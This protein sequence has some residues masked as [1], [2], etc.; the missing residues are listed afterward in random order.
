MRLKLSG[1]PPAP[2]VPAL[3]ACGQH[4][5]DHLGE[6]AAVEKVGQWVVVGHGVELVLGQIE[7]LA[8][9]AEAL[10]GPA[11]SDAGDDH[12]QGYQADRRGGAPWPVW[13][14][15]GAACSTRPAGT[16][17]VSACMPV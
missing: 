12:Q 3:L 8:L 2:P 11:R 6:S 10:F 14:P 15:N 16:A 17:R 5:G 13:L 9:L 1:P 7:R 4:L